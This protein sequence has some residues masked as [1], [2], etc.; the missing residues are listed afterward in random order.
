MVRFFQLA[1]HFGDAALL[2]PVSLVAIGVLVWSGHRQAALRFAVAVA[3]LMAVTVA[4][5]IGFYATGG[6]AYLDIL[7]PSGHAGFSVTVY[8]CCAAVLA[9]QLRPLGAI[10]VVAA[11][12]ALLVTILVSRIVLGVHSPA[13]VIMG[14]A[15][16]LICASTFVFWNP[17]LSQLRLRLPMI[18]V[19]VL[20]VATAS[21]WVGARR[22]NAERH[23]EHVGIMVGSSL[24]T[25]LPSDFRP[26]YGYTIR[27]GSHD[28]G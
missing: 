3:S 8:T 27:Q 21:A 14:C 25:L 16:G 6:D 17:G 28:G 5:K 13:E 20:A 24:G 7:S 4:L 22:F 10:A 11:V 12:V 15:V 9:K 26:G 18:A 23:I 1:T 2:V 19:V